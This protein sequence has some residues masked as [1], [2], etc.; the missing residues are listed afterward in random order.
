MA[1][2]PI[3]TWTGLAVYPGQ[4]LLN[5]EMSKII[6]FMCFDERVKAN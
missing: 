5:Q 3:G 6:T 1:W 4:T 2:R